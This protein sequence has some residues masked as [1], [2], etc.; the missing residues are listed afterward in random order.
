MA[1]GCDSRLDSL[2]M[3][4]CTICFEKYNETDQLPKL[5]ACGHTFCLTCHKG[6]ANVK[7]GLIICPTCKDKSTLPKGGVAQLKTNFELKHTMDAFEAQKNKPAVQSDT[8]ESTSA[9]EDENVQQ[10]D[11]AG[12]ADSSQHEIQ[13]LLSTVKALTLGVHKSGQVFNDIIDTIRGERHDVTVKR[14]DTLKTIRRE[15]DEIVKTALKRKEYLLQEVTK[16]C[17]QNLTLLTAYED[18]YSRKK[19][20]HSKFHGELMRDITRQQQDA[21]PSC[22]VLTRLCQSAQSRSKDLNHEFQ[23]TSK[24]LC[25]NDDSFKGI[26]EDIRSWGQVSQNSAVL[27]VQPRC[28]VQEASPATTDQH[29]D[30]LNHY[31][32]KSG[33]VGTYNAISSPC[34]ITQL[35]TEEFAVANK[36]SYKISICS[37]SSPQNKRSIQLKVSQAVTFNQGITGMCTSM[38]GFG[39]TLIISNP[40]QNELQNWDPL[41]GNLLNVFRPPKKEEF[42]PAGMVCSP[43]GRLYVCDR[44][45]HSLHVLQWYEL[46]AYW[47]CKKI[48]RIGHRGKEPGNFDNPSDVAL[49]PDG[50][51]AVADFKNDRIQIFDGETLVFK[52]MIATSGSELG[53]LRGP[54]GIATDS[55]GF[56]AV[57]EPLNHRVQLFTPGG[58]PFMTLGEAKEGPNYLNWPLGITITKAREVVVCDRGNDKVK[59]Y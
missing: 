48:A 42:D 9:K 14:E 23:I 27:T 25:F 58:K 12:A 4:C 38:T 35:S 50:E 57:S 45:N 44:K 33:A 55:E 51:I 41:G 3:F 5:L 18:E 8:K 22:E 59:V 21:K 20:D 2:D 17:E 7:K 6:W 1:E 39:E 13:H 32:L 40:D 53:Q 34:C 28:P 36:N 11:I 47:C 54:S 26:V 24:K 46:N 49:M 52:R 37:F 16:C 29:S 10:R 19:E 30:S 43:S 31:C 15:Y 56:M